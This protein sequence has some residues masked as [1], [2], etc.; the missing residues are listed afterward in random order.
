MK[1]YVINC[2]NTKEM[3]IKEEIEKKIELDN[4]SKKVGQVLVPREKY[5]MIR[6]NKKVQSEKNY[7]PGYIFIECDLNGEL[8]RSIQTIKG[9]S[10]FLKGSNGP[11]AMTE[12]DVRNMLKR[13]GEKDE[14][15]DETTIS[16]MYSIGQAVTVIDGPFSSFNGKIV[17][18]LASKNLLKV[19]VSIFSRKTPVELSAEQ[20]T[21]D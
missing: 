5:V 3:K 15:T 4:H 7:Y 9:V 21:V 13:A 19:E 11:I 10:G 2:V 6:N 1:W 8:M 18:V 20:I 16:D 17:E 14:V 12:R